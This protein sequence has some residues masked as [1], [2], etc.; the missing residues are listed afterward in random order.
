[1]YYKYSDY[2]KNKYGEK[3]YKLPVN[4]PVTCPNR[5]G[6]KGTGGCIFCSAVGAGFETLDNFIEVMKKI[7]LE[8]QESPELLANAPHNTPVLKVDETY[9][10]RNPN[11]KWTKA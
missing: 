3:V 7:A 11:L 2:L 6:T 1:M 9:A 8:A 10:A 4:I 5:D